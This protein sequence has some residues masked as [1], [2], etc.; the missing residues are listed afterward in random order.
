MQTLFF[1]HH[2]NI[3]IHILYE[4]PLNLVIFVCLLRKLLKITSIKVRAQF[5]C[6]LFDV[7]NQPWS[8]SSSG[9]RISK[10]NKNIFLAATV[11]EGSN[12]GSQM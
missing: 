8:L 10:T 11:C 6:L 1:S 4:G 2:K 9:I 5:V 3:S 12:G 7:S